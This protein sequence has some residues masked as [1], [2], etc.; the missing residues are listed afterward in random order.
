MK[1]FHRL[2]LLVFVT[3]VLYWY[4]LHL[5][6]LLTVSKTDLFNPPEQ[7]KLHLIFYFIMYISCSVEII[8]ISICIEP[9]RQLA[10][11]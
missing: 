6:C 4:L 5:Y 9:T 10:G 11:V 7:Y 2:L 1:F 8:S 3:P